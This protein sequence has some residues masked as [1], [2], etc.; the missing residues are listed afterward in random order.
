[1]VGFGL[2]VQVVEVLTTKSDRGLALWCRGDVGGRITEAD[3]ARLWSRCGRMG[4]DA[5]TAPWLLASRSDGEGWGHAYVQENIL[6]C[7]GTES[8]RVARAK[9]RTLR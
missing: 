9:E 1:M 6:S 7:H 5:T 3:A 4:D 8:R 2:T